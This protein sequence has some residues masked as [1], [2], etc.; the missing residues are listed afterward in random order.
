MIFEIHR[1]G[2]PLS[3]FVEMITF[4]EGLIVDH[5]I[6][7]LFPEGVI[8]VIIDLTNEQQYIFDNETLAACR[9]TQPQVSD[10]GYD[11]MIVYDVLF[12]STKDNY[13][14]FIM[15]SDGSEKKNISN[16][17]GVDWV[18]YAF[19]DKI[20]FIS[21]RDTAHRHYFLYE[22]DVNGN[23]LK[24]I[25]PLRL[26]DSWVS[27]RKDGTEFL[28]S[29]RKDGLRY[30]L[31]FISRDGAILKQLTSDTTQ[32]FNDPFFSPDGKE[33]VFRH[34]KNRRDRTENDELRIMKDDGS[35][36]RQLTHYPADDTTANWFDYHAG[37]PISEPNQNIISYGSVTTASSPSSLMEV[38]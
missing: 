26:E 33:I 28:V 20:Y 29:G 4:Y 22:M 12:D 2:Q 35:N 37:P 31:Y 30:T 27:S 17:P 8:E 36:M 11:L 21:D 15:K 1:P 25:C 38:I 16:H 13:E 24:K 6:E 10:P 34:K 9:N 3:D 5:S 14:V 7:R 32:Y 18:Y 23:N 19:E